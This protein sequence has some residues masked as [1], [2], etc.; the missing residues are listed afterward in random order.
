MLEHAH[1]RRAVVDHLAHLE[2]ALGQRNHL[3]GAHLADHLG[4]DDVEGAALRGDDEAVVELAERQRPHAVRVA[5]GDDRVLGHHHGRE[6]ALEARHDVG[7]GV[8]DVDP[9]SSL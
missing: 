4:A 2:P 5:E 8:L 3:A 6:G 7:D 9:L 1:R